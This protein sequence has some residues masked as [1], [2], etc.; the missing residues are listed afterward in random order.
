MNTAHA[1]IEGQRVVVTG[2][3]TSSRR[4]G[5]TLSF[6]RIRQSESL[7]G[8]EKQQHPPAEQI[9]IVF[10][11]DLF[12]YAST[13]ET[14]ID[15][16]DSFHSSAFPSMKRAAS[17]GDAVVASCIWARAD[18]GDNASSNGGC[19]LDLCVERWRLVR[20]TITQV[21]GPG[22]GTL[23]GN[24]GGPPA[25]WTE[26]WARRS[27]RIAAAGWVNCPLCDAT[28]GHILSRGVGLARHLDA[29]HTLERDKVADRAVHATAAAGMSAG[30][31]AGDAA[32]SDISVSTAALRTAAIAAWHAELAGRADDAGIQLKRSA[33]ESSQRSRPD[34]CGR[35]TGG[36]CQQQPRMG[37]SFAQNSQHASE[38]PGSEGSE[39]SSLEQL[40]P[41]LM[42]ARD[43]DVATV[44]RMCASGWSVFDEASLD[45]HGASALDWASGAGHLE[46]VLLLAPHAANVVACRRDGRGPAHWAARHG[47]TEVL[48]HLLG[49]A[50]GGSLAAN[51]RTTNGT[52][53]LMFA[54]YGGHVE[55]AAALHAAHAD[56]HAQNAWGCDAGHFAALGGSVDAC[57]W[58]AA[59]GVALERKQRNGH[60]A[61]HKAAE[62]G[63]LSCCRFLLGHLTAVQ[64][65]RVGRLEVERMGQCTEGAWERWAGRQKNAEEEEGVI[66]T[67]MGKATETCKEPSSCA[68]A[69]ADKMRQHA[70][71]C[72][73]KRRQVNLPSA[74]ARR[75]ASHAAC[76]DLLMAAGL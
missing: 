7:V 6:M 24:N 11:S 50:G 43:G 21:G 67:K 35:A 64:R 41:G 2:T 57:R 56:L 22:V 3:V 42:A 76:A 63:H 73:Q 44:Q 32:R 52:T 75:Q 51:A 28:S 23:G 33:G 4:H 46:C 10:R 62:Q 72:H 19:G 38:E 70:E 27:G 1:P 30:G 54:C 49:L 36:G 58:L 55:T 14:I 26:P 40:H 68:D 71:Q 69:L 15:G 39:G 29:R 45:R 25:L 61:L 66:E 20:R 31:D 59:Q 48:R 5:K 60:S 17:M 34:R 16:V 12:D 8:S 37:A 9:G 13:E 53:M 18:A 74:L 65:E 47:R